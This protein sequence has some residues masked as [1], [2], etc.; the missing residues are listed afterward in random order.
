LQRS[1]TQRGAPDWSAVTFCAAP[2]LARK[3]RGRFPRNLHGAP[4]LL[5]T[6]NTALRRDVEQWFRSVG[7]EPRVAGEFEDAALAK[8]V[9]TEGLGFTIVPSVVAA[10]A[11]ERY[12]FVPLGSTKQCQIELFLITAER[13]IE[14]P[15]LVELAA[16]VRNGAKAKRRRS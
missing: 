15:V 10:E 4:A 7:V 8:I 6:P 1:G 2:A 12:G 14:H 16:H 5:P 3:L 9:A 13:R 11:V